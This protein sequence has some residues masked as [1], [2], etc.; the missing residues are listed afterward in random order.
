MT[1]LDFY[2]SIA[3]VTL[4]QDAA[5]CYISKRKFKALQGAIHAAF[6]PITSVV[7]IVV[8]TVETKDYQEW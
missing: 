6:W 8:A 3:L 7:A 2:L 1:G 5:V 4:A